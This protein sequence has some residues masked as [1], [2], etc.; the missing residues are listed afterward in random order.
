MKILEENKVYYKNYIQTRWIGF[1]ALVAAVVLTLIIPFVYKS[2]FEITNYYSGTAFALP[3]LS[4]IALVLAA[5]KYTERY[6][7]VALFIIILISFLVFIETS[8][9]YLTSAFFGG[10]TG[11]ILKQAGFPYSFCTIAHLVGLILSGVAVFAK[12]A[13]EVKNV[14]NAEEV[15]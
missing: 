10:I 4:L 3:F 5:C 2:G 1:Y 12:P 8:Y 7:P 6:A 11:N 15:A 14:T 9:M 13:R